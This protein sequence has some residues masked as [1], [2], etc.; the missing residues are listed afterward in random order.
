MDLLYSSILPLLINQSGDSWRIVT[1]ARIG[2]HIK[3]GMKIAIRH[4][5]NAPDRQNYY[6]FA[7]LEVGGGLY[8]RTK[9]YKI[10]ENV[11]RSTS[12]HQDLDDLCPKFH[13]K[14][15]K[16]FNYN[17]IRTHM[18]LFNKHFLCFGIPGSL[19]DLFIH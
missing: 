7:F 15:P 3:V 4:G 19:I 13:T 1:S 6:F 10:Q 8:L 16:N 18:S 11:K 2:R 14:I 12:Q 9:P 5:R 17:L